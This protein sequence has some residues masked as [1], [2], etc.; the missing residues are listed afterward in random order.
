MAGE[1]RRL[2][3]LVLGA[4]ILLIAGCATDPRVTEIA[5]EYYNLGN[6]YFELD[7][8]ERSYEFYLKARELDPTIIA[9]NYNLARL[10]LERDDPQAALSLLRELEEEDEDNLLIQETIAYALNQLGDQR[11]AETL[12]R[13]IVAQDPGRVSALYNLSLLTEEPREAIDLLR[14]AAD[15]AVEDEEILRRLIS[16]LSSE[17]SA[18]SAAVYLERLR[19]LV[20]DDRSALEDVAQ[21]YEA[22]GYPQEAVETFELLIEIDPRE[23]EYYFSQARILLTTI[24]NDRN[25]LIALES[26]L[27]EGFSDS[28]AIEALLGDADLVAP[29]QVEALLDEYGRLGELEA[30]EEEEGEGQEAGDPEE[31][32]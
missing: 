21:Q 27:E 3:L 7:E 14:T 6:L 25:G 22:L 29:A 8:Y 23:E 28:Q 4:I 12:Y 2:S 32:G 1:R 5:S 16:L 10:E 9:A 30:E 24:G 15:L 19:R 26:A 20:A 18:E 13:E 11:E 17:E 31:G